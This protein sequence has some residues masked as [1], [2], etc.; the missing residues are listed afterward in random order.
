ML[1]QMSFNLLHVNSEENC[2]DFVVLRAE[3]EHGSRHCS[4]HVEGVQDDSV[5]AKAVEQ[6]LTAQY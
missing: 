2:Q 4:L 5:V 1:D 6:T 3:C